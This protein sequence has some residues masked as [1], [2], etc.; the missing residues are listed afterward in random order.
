VSL[1][2]VFR[3]PLHRIRGAFISKPIDVEVLRGNR[4]PFAR[5]KAWHMTQRILVV[6]DMPLNVWGFPGGHYSR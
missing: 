2:C 1:Y 4:G 3:A 5:S 6:N